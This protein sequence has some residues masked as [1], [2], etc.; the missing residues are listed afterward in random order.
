M[1]LSSGSIHLKRMIAGSPIGQS[2]DLA[3]ERRLP[4]VARGASMAPNSSHPH[5]SL[6]DGVGALWDFFPFFL[7]QY[8]HCLDRSRASIHQQSTY[9]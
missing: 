4:R 7:D 3:L 1:G 6:A 9:L 2:P 8:T 5:L